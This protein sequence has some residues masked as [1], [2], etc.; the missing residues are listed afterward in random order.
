MLVVVGGHTRNIGKTTL[1]AQIVGAF[2]QMHW[3]ADPELVRAHVACAMKK[4]RL[5]SGSSFQ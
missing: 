5:D 1:A 4:S 3:T 2:P